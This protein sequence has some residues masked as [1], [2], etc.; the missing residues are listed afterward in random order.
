[1]LIAQQIGAETGNPV[2]ELIERGFGPLEG[3]IMA[4]VSDEESAAAK[5]QLEP[6]ADILSR[7]V[8]ALLDLA[9]KHAG[10]KVMIV[11]HG[12]T[13]RT[14]RDALAGTREPQGVENG[15]MLDVDLIRLE[16]IASELDLVAL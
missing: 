9:S 15:E 6:H 14:I 7:A 3:R 5:D 1:M 13:M 10:R 16:Q 12:A 8:P 4:E 11:S 2:P